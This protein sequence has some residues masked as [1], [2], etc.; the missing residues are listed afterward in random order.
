MSLAEKPA[1]EAVRYRNQASQRVLSVLTAFGGHAEARGVS[2][3][4]REL[5]M[6]KNMAYRALATLTAEGYLTRDVTG[7]RYQLGPRLFAFA[8]G[9]TSESDIV[10][11]SRPVLEQ[12]HRLTGE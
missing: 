10:A 12:L 8:A 6:N 2:E 1:P 4:A 5:G 11:L 3:I 7:E 9:G